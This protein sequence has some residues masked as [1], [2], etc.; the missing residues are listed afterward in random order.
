MVRFS[1]RFIREQEIQHFMF[2]HPLVKNAVANDIHFGKELT[3]II[4]RS[5]RVGED[6]HAQ[7]LEQ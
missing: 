2:R 1:C 5:T 4:Y 6:H 7:N 3:A